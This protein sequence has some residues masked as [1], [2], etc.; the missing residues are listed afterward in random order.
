MLSHL[1]P[2]FLSTHNN[3][4]TVGNGLTRYGTITGITPQT[5]INA[6]STCIP[7][8]CLITE[9]TVITESTSGSGGNITFVFHKNNVTQLFV[10]VISASSAA[11][12]Y[13]NTTDFWC[14]VGDY[15]GYAITNSS[16]ATTPQYRTLIHIYG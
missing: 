11:G 3:S 16:N 6:A 15:I 2:K 13:T 12:R 1:R 8:K 14:D 5:T 4:L 9:F 10:L 7:I